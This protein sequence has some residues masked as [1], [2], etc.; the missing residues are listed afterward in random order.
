MARRLR[1]FSL[2]NK[3]LGLRLNWRVIYWALASLVL[4]VPAVGMQLSDEVKWG[5]RDF[6]VMGLLV[7]LVG[8]ALEAVVRLGMTR[9]KQGL[10]LLGVGAAFLLIWAELAVGVFH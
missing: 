9:A 3:S 5:P 7:V 4:I 6:L 10:A 1:G 2:M 8:L